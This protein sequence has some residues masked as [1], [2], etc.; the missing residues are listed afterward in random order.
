MKG[1]SIIL[2]LRLLVALAEAHGDHSPQKCLVCFS[3]GC[4]LGYCHGFAADLVLSLFFYNS[5]Y[6]YY[7][8]CTWRNDS[9]HIGTN[10][11]LELDFLTFYKLDSCHPIFFL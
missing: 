5:F 10:I 1:I 3:F 4:V 11:H 2:L 9:H 8:A 6:Q 7:F